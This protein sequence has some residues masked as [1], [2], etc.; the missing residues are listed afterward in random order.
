MLPPKVK[1]ELDK[2]GPREWL[3]VKKTRTTTT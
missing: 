3:W 1:K 2:L